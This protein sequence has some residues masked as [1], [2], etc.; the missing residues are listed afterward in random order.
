MQAAIEQACPTAFA[1]E[2][3]PR[4]VDIPTQPNVP[5]TMTIASIVMPKLLA[6]AANSQKCSSNL[7]DVP[8]RTKKPKQQ[9]PVPWQHD[10]I[11][12]AKLECQPRARHSTTDRQHPAKTKPGT[13]KNSEQPPPEGPAHGMRKHILT[14]AFCSILPASRCEHAYTCKQGNCSILACCHIRHDLTYSRR[15]SP[16]RYDKEL[17]QCRSC[18]PVCLIDELAAATILHQLVY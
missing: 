3:L 16:E 8:V 4:S 15:A 10:A 7:K 11:E 9:T 18:S 14:H 1:P 13:R 5:R 6:T 12:S 2:H 17:Q